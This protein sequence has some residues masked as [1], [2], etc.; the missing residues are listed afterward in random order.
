M[1]CAGWG[2][3]GGGAVPSRTYCRSGMN[4][5]SFNWIL[6]GLCAASGASGLG[7]Q[8]TWTRQLALGLG[9]ELPS[10][11]AVMTAFFLGLALGAAVLGEWIRRSPQPL[12]WAAGLELMIGSWAVLTTLF[13]SGLNELARQGVGLD[14]SP[15]RQWSVTLAVA[16][17]GLLPATTAMGA[18]LAAWER[19]LVQRAGPGAWIAGLYAANTGGAVA[20]VLLT[21]GILHPAW[22]L[23]ATTWGWAAVNGFC[24][25][26]LLALSS[27]K[28]AAEIPKL[29][30]GAG[31]AV[32][33]KRLLWLRLAVGGGLGLGFE[34]WT[35]RLLNLVLEGTVYT[36]A[37]VLVVWLLGTAVGAAWARG[38]LQTVWV[39]GTL[40]V[41]LVGAGWAMAVSPGVFEWLRNRWGDSGWAVTGAEG[42]VVALIVGPS[43]VLMGLL[44]CRWMDDAVRAGSGVGAALAWNTVGAGLAPVVVGVLLFPRLGGKGILVVL[45][46]GYGVLLAPRWSALGLSVGGVVLLGSVLP[47]L[48]LLQIPP[49][50]RVVEFREG[51]LDSV[52]VL[53]QFGSNVVLTVNNRFVMGGTAS[54]AAAARHSYLPLM[55][56]PEPRR[57]LFLGLG[58]GISFAALGAQS[59]LTAEAVELVPDIVAVQSRF[60]PHNHL[61]AGLRVNVGDARRWVRT[62]PEKYDVVIA[63]LFH[64]ARDGAGAL[65]TFEHFSAL[66][67]VLRE[68]G[69]VCQWLPLYQLDEPTLRSIV[70]AF[71]E[72]F[73]D[74]QAFLLRPNI[75]TPV[76]GL[77]GGRNSLTWD[78][79]WWE[80]R[81]ADP[82]LA[83][84]LKRTGLNSSESLFGLWLAGPEELRT[85]AAGSPRNTDDRPA[86]I[87]SAPA[88]SWRRTGSPGAD[89]VRLLTRFASAGASFPLANSE[90]ADRAW[91][92]RVAEYRIA[93]DEYLRGLVAEDE[94]RPSDAEQ[95]F[96]ASSRASAVFTS[97][98]SRLVTRAMSLAGERPDEARRLLEALVQVRPD[99]PLAAELLRR[100]GAGKR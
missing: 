33:L 54:A 88:A 65:Y 53:E 77:I 40:P 64:P 14:P 69:I 39:L 97:G 57:A 26:V 19:G 55:L 81:T 43:T 38:R 96:L 82:T 99:Q 67:A 18:T 86:V 16:L 34:V 20:G 71:L 36:Y 48:Q 5:R 51:S 60:A 68:S 41:A 44:F 28:N 11:W 23:R 6:H 21:V 73:P 80:R 59:G 85:F 49:R 1:R 47:G 15:V 83:D 95:H 25:L 3:D 46:L 79:G 63:D 17:V 92:N 4:V 66:R 52:A 84:R 37:T 61:P 10:T 72:V 30:A 35:V 100:M 75:D 32:G 87:Y 56:H 94:G 98:Y 12:R 62:T 24:A 22:G 31:Q 70:G 74:A 29:G 93:R 76:L 13:G 42:V 91:G 2:N 27:G 78:A 90:A 45:A 7:L 8:L 89:L 58:T 9:H 50:S